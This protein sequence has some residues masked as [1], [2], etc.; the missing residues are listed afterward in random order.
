V[1]VICTLKLHTLGGRITG[2]GNVAGLVLVNGT[3]RVE[4]P[5]NNDGTFQMAKVGEDQPY[6]I[7]V[8]SAPAGKTCTVQNGSG[9]MRTDDLPLVATVT[10]TPT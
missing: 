3:D 1:N 9:Y 10:C 2:L 7:S 5:A 8:L 6:G 4:V